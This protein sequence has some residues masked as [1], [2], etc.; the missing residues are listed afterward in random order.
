MHVH[1]G[2]YP[3]FIEQ[4]SSAGTKEVVYPQ[5]Y[6]E[7][8]PDFPVPSWEVRTCLTE[9]SECSGHGY[10][11]A[12]T[13]KCVCDYSYY[14]TAS[15]QSCDSQCDGDIYDGQCRA[16]RTYFIGGLFAGMYRIM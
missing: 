9:T 2:N 15:P 3:Y 16:R 11:D 14:S 12:V 5:E 10:C 1:T 4:V 13:A 7:R 6:K 8:D